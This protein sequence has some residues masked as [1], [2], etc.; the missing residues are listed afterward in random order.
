MHSDATGSVVRKI[1]KLY[2]RILYYALVVRHPEVQTSP[3]PLAEMLS[4]EHT[5]VEITHFLTKWLYNMKKI[6]YKETILT[7][8]EVDFSWPMLHS[9]NSFNTQTLDNYLQICWEI[10]SPKSVCIP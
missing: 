9:V 7:Q 2:K 1:D 10:L 8:V 4:S 5:N 3:V 6:I